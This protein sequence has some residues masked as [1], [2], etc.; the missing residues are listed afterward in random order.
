MCNIA[1]II[2][3]KRKNYRDKTQIKKKER[4]LLFSW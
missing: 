1:K 2:E 3:T 4:N